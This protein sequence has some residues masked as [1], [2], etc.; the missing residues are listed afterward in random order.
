LQLEHT[1]SLAHAHVSVLSR[2]DALE[3]FLE[4]RV[5]GTPVLDDDGNCL[6]VISMTDIMWVESRKAM[7]SFEFPFYPQ[8][9]LEVDGEQVLVGTEIERDEAEVML[10]TKVSERMSSN[11]ITIGPNDLLN[12]GAALMIEKKVNRLP[13][14]DPATKNLPHHHGK[15]IGLITRLDVMRCLAAVWL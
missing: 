15:V 6:G 9:E 14:V 7:K 8:Q 13:V 1:H 11:A 4:K 10:D 3:L 5:S 12:E 2:R